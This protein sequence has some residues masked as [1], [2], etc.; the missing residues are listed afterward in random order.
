MNCE[1]IVKADAWTIHPSLC[2][3]AAV[4]VRV[5]LNEPICCYGEGFLKQTG[6]VD[7]VIQGSAGDMI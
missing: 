7:C 6:R 2:Q 1:D 4:C 5:S 3:Q